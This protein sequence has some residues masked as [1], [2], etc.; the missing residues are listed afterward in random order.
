MSY[1]QTFFGYIQTEA[2]LDARVIEVLEAFPFDETYPFPNC[3]SAPQQSRGGS[4]V[5]FARV[6]K[7]YEDHQQGW[8]RRFEDLLGQLPAICAEVSVYQEHV[9]PEIRIAYFVT[10]PYAPGGRRRWLKLVGRT[11]PVWTEESETEL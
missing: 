11:E 5:S 7:W 1:D 8:V 10:E 4:V 3:F 2:D 6:F 9:M